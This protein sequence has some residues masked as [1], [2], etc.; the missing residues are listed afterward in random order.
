MYVVQRIQHFRKNIF[1]QTK[2]FSKIKHQ[3]CYSKMNEF[4]QLI[5]EVQQ[6]SD[7]TYLDL[8]YVLYRWAEPKL[9]KE[10]IN[11]FISRHGNPQK[12][13]S[14]TIL[15]LCECF[16]FLPQHIDSQTAIVWIQQKGKLKVF[17]QVEQVVNLIYHFILNP[18]NTSRYFIK[19]QKAM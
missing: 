19:G 16:S 5:V 6:V 4:T 15:I 7:I 1:H 17:T 2:S 12:P 3:Y 10:N 14:G 8:F 18:L 11:F 13:F 9:N